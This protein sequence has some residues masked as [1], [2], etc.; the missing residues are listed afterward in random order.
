VKKDGEWNLQFVGNCHNGVKTLVEKL[1]LSNSVVFVQYVNHSEAIDYMINANVLLL[2]IPEIENN[3]GILT[4]KLFEYLATGNPILNI[5][6]KDGDAAAILKENAI[7]VTLNPNDKQA[8]MD[9]ILNSTP[10]NTPSNLSEHK[11]SRRNL[12]R[13][14]A[15]LIHQT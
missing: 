8:I 5:G 2:I 11:F 14:M 7:S 6:P 1:N 3:K 12:T 4:G 15:S 13:E 10:T 9:F